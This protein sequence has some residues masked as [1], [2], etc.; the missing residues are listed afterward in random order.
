MPDCIPSL[1]TSIRWAVAATWC[2]AM[3]P[4]ERESRAPISAT[5]A[6]ADVPVEQ[7]AG[8][9]EKTP[10][11]NDILS[12]RPSSSMTASSSGWRS[13]RAGGSNAY[14]SP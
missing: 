8:A 1:S 4:G 11:S 9:S 13:G 2:W 10:I 7:P 5:A 14:R 12:G 6:A 3:R